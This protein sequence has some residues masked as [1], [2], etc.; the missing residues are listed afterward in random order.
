MKTSTIR[1]QRGF[2]EPDLLLAI[3]ALAILALVGLRLIARH[4]AYWWLI[5]LVALG[6]WLAVLYAIGILRPRSRRV[7]PNVPTPSRKDDHAA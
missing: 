7:P 6:L 1:A 4:P 5:V 2:F 3:A